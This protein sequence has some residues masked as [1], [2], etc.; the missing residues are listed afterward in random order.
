MNIEEVK[1]YLSSLVVVLRG[2]NDP[3]GMQAKT[4]ECITLLLEHCQE[5]EIDIKL[6]RDKI[7]RAPDIDPETIKVYD[8]EKF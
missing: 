5:V 4:C 1:Q 8:K 6:L 7:E 3:T 2:M